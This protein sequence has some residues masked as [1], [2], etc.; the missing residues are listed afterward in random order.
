MA[1]GTH[2]L[3]LDPACGMV[4]H[5]RAIVERMMI[6][7]RLAGAEDLGAVAALIVENSAARGGTLTGEWS[8]AR[9]EEWFARGDAIV[10]AHKGARLVG[11]LLT[12]EKGT[13]AGPAVAAMLHAY[14]GAPSAYVYGP[15]CIEAEQRGRGVLAALHAEARRHHAGREAVLFIREDNARSLAAHRRLGMRVVGEFPL[16][17][18]RHL[19]LSDAAA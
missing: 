2:R 18:Q 15:V 3:A 4:G 9:I 13:A 1:G 12:G 16:A 19:V 8:L 10:V 5:R 17:G 14:S 6:E 11:T 7:T